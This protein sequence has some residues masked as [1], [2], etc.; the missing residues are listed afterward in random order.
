VTFSD[1]L[2]YVRLS[3]LQRKYF[4]KFRL[5]IKLGKKD[6]ENLILRAAAA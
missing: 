1:A 3:I 4:S 5:K 2:S 6:L